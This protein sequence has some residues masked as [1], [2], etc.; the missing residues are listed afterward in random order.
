MNTVKYKNDAELRK[1]RKAEAKQ[2]KRRRIEEDGGKR[3][4]PGKSSSSTSNKSSTDRE[5]VKRK[6]T[7]DTTK[8]RFGRVMEKVP[9]MKR[10]RYST[11]SIAL[12]TS[13]IQNCQTHEL[14]TQLVGQISRACA[15]YHVDEVVIFDDHLGKEEK[16]A[17]DAAF[18]ARIL[19]Y[20]ECPQYLRRNFFP[21]HY[22]LKY[23]GLLCPLDAPHHVRVGEK[24][25][26]REGVSLSD[27]KA[28]KTSTDTTS[29]VNIGVRIPVVVDRKIPPNVRCTVEVD[30]KDYD[31][32]RRMK[33]KI[34]SPA[35]PREDDGTYWGYTTRVAKSIAAALKECPYEGGYDLKIGTSERGDMNVDSVKFSFPTPQYK[36]LLIVF[37]GVAGIEECVDADE[38]LKV[39]GD[40]SCSLFDMWVNTCPFQGSRTIRTEEAVLISLARLRPF[41]AKNNE[42]H[43]KDSTSMQKVDTNIT[44]SDSASSEESSDDD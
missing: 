10:P 4:R 3:R 37:G 8:R 14:K 28:G 11:V 43:P 30:I 24:S 26:Y 7:K 42:V 31:R 6:Q 13:I 36:H 12:P 29:F 2:L 18:M 27:E 19:Q 40:D 25:K 17:K 15:I 41:I 32:P 20:M 39:A 33:G 1:E 9:S 21:M 35:A 16:S 5:K 23:A 22:D 38:T 44:F 34:V